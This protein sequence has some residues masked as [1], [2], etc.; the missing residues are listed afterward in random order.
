MSDQEVVQGEMP[1][2]PEVTQVEKPEVEAEEFDKER[3][4]ETIKKLRQFEKQSKALERKLAEYESKEREREEAKLSETEKLKRQLAEREAQ[5]KQLER[6]AMQRKAA[7]AAGLPPAF[8]ERLK[9]ETQEELEADANA[10]KEALPK[11]AQAKVNP[12]NPGSNASDGETLAQR[13]AR[14]YGG[15]V[16]LFDPATVAKLGGGVTYTT[17]SE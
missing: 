9:G 4:L 6:A 14:L 15:N 2:E 1:A 12:T 11:A 10:L 7:E 17:K 3:A 5:L 13:R 16:D 8:A